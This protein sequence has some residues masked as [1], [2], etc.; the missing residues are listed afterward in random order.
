MWK[1]FE[2]YVCSIVWMHGFRVS[3]MKYLNVFYFIRRH[4]GTIQQTLTQFT[5]VLARTH[6]HTFHVC[7]YVCRFECVGI[8]KTFR[9]KLQ[10]YISIHSA[11]R[12]STKLVSVCVRLLLSRIPSRLTAEWTDR[13]T[14]YQ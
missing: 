5:C 4:Q 10:F 9:W 6:K 12:Q 1:Y 2:M 11:R 7:M 3:A 8:V 13:Q 14:K